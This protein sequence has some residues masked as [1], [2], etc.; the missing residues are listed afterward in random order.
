[1]SSFHAPWVVETRITMVHPWRPIGVYS[2]LSAAVA[3]WLPLAKKSSALARIR[4]R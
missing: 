3:A 1:M 2:A 4:A